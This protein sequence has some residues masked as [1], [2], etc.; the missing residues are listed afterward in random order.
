M[1]IRFLA[2][3]EAS[4]PYQNDIYVKF[5]G[6]Q[7]FCGIHHMCLWNQNFF[8]HFNIELTD[9]DFSKYLICLH[10]AC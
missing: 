4:T 7:S 10:V 1:T 8:L 3:M 6:P 2:N 9:H 5:L